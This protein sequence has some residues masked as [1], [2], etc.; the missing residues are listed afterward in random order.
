MGVNDPLPVRA[1]LFLIHSYFARL[2][3]GIIAIAWII[4]GAVIN[5]STCDTNS[6]ITAEVC[7]CVSVLRGAHVHVLS[8]LSLFCFSFYMYSVYAL[9]V[10]YAHDCSCT[11]M[12]VCACTCTCV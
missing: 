11:C 1:S 9:A 5:M 4:V 6:P 12:R 3:I 8:V 7:V 10:H 2:V